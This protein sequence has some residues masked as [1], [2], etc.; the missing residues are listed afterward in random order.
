MKKFSVAIHGTID[1]HSNIQVEAEDWMGA[2][3]LALSKFKDGK[4]DVYS[5]Y[6]ELLN[7][8]VD[9]YHIADVKELD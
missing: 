8:P 4:V 2:E 6:G 3:E 9:N 1:C 5:S 7:E